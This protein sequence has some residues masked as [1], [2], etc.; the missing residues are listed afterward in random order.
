MCT[1]RR[2]YSV[3]TLLLIRIYIL[4]RDALDSLASRVGRAGRTTLLVARCSLIG[5]VGAGALALGA[6][7]SFAA[8]I[9]SLYDA[10]KVCAGASIREGSETKEAENAARLTCKHPTGRPCWG[11][12]RTC[13]DP[14]GKSRFRRSYAVSLVH[15]PYCHPVGQSGDLQTHLHALE[16]VDL[17]GQLSHLQAPAGQEH[18]P[19]QL[20]LSVHCLTSRKEPLPKGGLGAVEEKGI[21]Y[22]QVEVLVESHEQPLDLLGQLA[23]LHAP[24]GQ[25]HDPE[26]LVCQHTIE[27]R[28]RIVS[29]GVVASKMQG[30]TYVQ[31][32]VLVESHEQPLDLL[33]QLA[34]LQAPGGH[35][36]EPPQ[37]SISMALRI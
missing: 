23:H 4:S 1:C 16:S 19:E 31:V 20:S 14:W 7:T 35:E 2:S 3:S 8:A 27:R 13:I 32:E 28:C 21:T 17:L 15:T 37:L 9:Q 22:V 18:D 24:G 10:L 36:H 26:Q 29:I 6:G 25:E 30:R 12:W 5:A 33:G 34:H 11:S